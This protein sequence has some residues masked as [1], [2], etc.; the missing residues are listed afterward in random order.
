RVHPSFAPSAECDRI[1]D[2]LEED[3]RLD[4]GAHLSAAENFLGA[5]AGAGALA[6]SVVVDDTPDEAVSVGEGRHR[7]QEW[8]DDLR[9][10]EWRV[11]QHAERVH[12]DD[13]GAE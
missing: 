7:T 13:L 12:V 11:G 9:L 10:A 1:T 4:P 5:P 2:G 8:L 3:R 6:A